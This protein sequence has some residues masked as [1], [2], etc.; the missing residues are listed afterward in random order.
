LAAALAA[1]E[2]PSPE[3]VA[4]AGEKA[5]LK[6]WIAWACLV[7]VAIG[8]PVVVFLTNQV[9]LYRQVPLDRPPEVLQS[10]AQAVVAEL[11]FTEP[12]V[13]SAH[14]FVYATDYLAFL[15]QEAPKEDWS[16]RLAEP[17]PAVIYWYRQSPQRLLKFNPLGLRVTQQNPPST[18]PGMVQIELDTVGRLVRF[19]RVP[20]DDDAT[21]DESGAVDWSALF[22]AAGLD[23]DGFTPEDPVFTP[24]AYADRRVAW[25]GSYA[26]RT[27]LPIRVEAAALRGRPVLFRV[28]GSW[29]ESQDDS[30]P[31][32]PGIVA[33]TLAFVI[34]G[35]FIAACLM[36]RW[37]LRHGR[38]D[39]RGAFRLAVYF[40][41]V[42]FLAWIFGATHVAALDELGYMV[43][44]VAMNLF[45]ATLIWVVYLAL[46]PFVRR[47]WPDTLVSWTRLLDGRFKDPLVGRDLLLGSA[48][49]MAL[50]VFDFVMYLSP[51][52]IGSRVQYQVPALDTLLGGRIVIW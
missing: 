23:V 49:A 26:N 40:F 45:V 18:L 12:P 47:R 15:Q 41:S 19:A 7:L 14:G 35:L 22:A 27:D 44:A 21:R 39:R 46:E 4:A 11:G 13:D 34:L 16:P 17:P 3:L 30:N 29:A 38:G 43:L 25:E 33:I 6:P 36:A 28:V 8:L 52:W 20:T 31:S 51:A 42:Q 5:G 32:G 9:M 1:G 50:V 2:T 10:K 48:F 37:N 24:P